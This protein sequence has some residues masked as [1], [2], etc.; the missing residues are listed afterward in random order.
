[1]ILWPHFFVNGTVPWLQVML[2]GHSDEYTADKKMKVTIAFN[3]FAS[4]LI[5]RMPR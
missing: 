2:L 1:M 3:R 4:G 5:E